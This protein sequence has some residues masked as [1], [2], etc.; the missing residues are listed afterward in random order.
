M[1]PLA[2]AFTKTRFLAYLAGIFI[3]GMISGGLLHS[4]WAPPKKDR[5]RDPQQIARHI[6]ERF[7]SELKLSD[8]QLVKLRPLLR[9]NAEAIHDFDLQTV[10]KIDEY[11]DRSRD[12]FIAALTP[13]QLPRFKEMEAKRKAFMRQ[14]QADS[15]PQ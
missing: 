5:P 2:P 11:I 1:S 7:R 12:E 15:P 6:E 14:K 3:A 13:D 9:R 4:W 8:E 10:K